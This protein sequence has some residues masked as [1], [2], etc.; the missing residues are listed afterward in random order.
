MNPLAMLWQD[1]CTVTVR[2]P[3]KKADKSTGHK[4]QV[5]LQEAPCKLSFL[6]S[7]TSANT[8]VMNNKIASATKQ[9]IKLFLFPDAEIPPGSKIA[10]THKGKTT[11]FTHSG[12]PSVFSNH[13]EIIL[14]LWQE[15]A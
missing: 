7:F 4:D 14:E 3:Y 8:P 1:T 6:Y 9:T 13:Q 5:I 2:K 12:V 10:V 11:L 15:W